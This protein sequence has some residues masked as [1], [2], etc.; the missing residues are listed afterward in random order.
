MKKSLR[1]YTALWTSKFIIKTMN[2][3][4]RRATYLPGMIAY[5]LC[6]DI[7]KYMKVPK[8]TIAL[9]GTNGKTTTANMISDFLNKKKI[10]Y[11]HNNYG[12]NTVEG[13]IA[14]FIKFSDLKGNLD[15]EYGIIEVD[16]RSSYRV[17]EHFTPDYLIVTNLFRDSS[18][19]NAHADYIFNILED[20]VSEKTKLILN[21]DDLIS[22]LLDKDR[23]KTFFSINLLDGEEEERNSRI[24]DVENCPKCNHR[25]TPE[26]IRYNHIGRYHCENCGFENFKPDYLVKS[27]DLENRF[28][29]IEHD[30]KEY[31]FNLQSSNIVDLYN[32]L[33]AITALSEIGFS[34][35]E[36]IRNFEDVEVVK[37]RYNDYMI[38]DKRLVYI[39]AKAIN[40]ISASRTFD[41]IRKQPGNIAVIFGNSKHD[42]GYKNSENTSWL[43]DLDFRYLKDSENIKQYITCGKRFKDQ[44][45]ALLLSGIDKNKI[46]SIDGWSGVAEAIDYD[47]ID[48]I[49]L[50][51]DIDTL[52]LT[53]KVKK[54][55]E[56]I[57]QE[58]LDK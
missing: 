28:A 16:E 1:F 42:I 24:K 27:A 58:R 53:G 26:F 55:I 50:L 40:P 31:K 41:Y 18:K 34:M 33:A 46:I 52:D 6:P 49:F 39:M 22:S 32:L 9:T 7:I 44:E 45:V 47:N 30:S 17:Y 29:I 13:I 3:L 36:L 11:I 15:Y 48:T 5:K 57:L 35:K 38:G 14:S 43:Y 54:E 56:N 20:S 51:N 2:L 4:G 19:R 37:S 21:S 12:S 10:K 23:E 8:T 25:L